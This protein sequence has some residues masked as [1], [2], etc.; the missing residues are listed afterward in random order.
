MPLP[1]NPPHTPQ[2]LIS[3]AIDWS[4]ARHKL[5]LITLI[6]IEGNA[7]YPIGSQMLVNEKGDY[8]GQITGGCAEQAI[9]DQA[10][11]TIRSASNTNHRYGLNSPYFDIQL[12]CGSGIDVFIDVAS[13]QSDYLAI[14]QSLAT[15][16]VVSQQ[17][18]TQWGR[19]SKLYTPNQRVIICGQGPI[20]IG[21]AE[22]ARLSGFE[23][24]CIGQNKQTV[25]QLAEVG[26][27]AVE[28]SQLGG[29]I[30]DYCDAYTALVSLF[31]EH[32]H[33]TPILHSALR[34]NAFY[35]GAL[36]SRSTHAQ[37][38]DALTKLG[39]QESQLMRIH[40][41]VGLDIGARTPGHIALSVLAHIVEQ[42]PRSTM[43]GL[44]PGGVASND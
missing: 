40:G 23:V 35:I 38:I 3:K 9:A 31:H 30:L 42:L 29:D 1:I 28:L 17:L 21:L 27:A 44:R 34:S 7:P 6:G 36:G 26:V 13:Q 43:L 11:E 16:N 14:A 25:Q 32:D 24:I 41:P 2:N 19:F 33:E 12:P 20:L 18:E 5:A 10:S 39:N 37:R 15:R 22:M 4:R 8:L